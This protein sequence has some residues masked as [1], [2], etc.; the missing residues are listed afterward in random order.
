M[1]L[2]DLYGT[3]GTLRNLEE[4]FEDFLKRKNAI[5]LIRFGRYWFMNPNNADIRPIFR[6]NCQK[7][8]KLVRVHLRLTV[9]HIHF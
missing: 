7:L 4:H 8:G 3:L 9:T 6:I 1:T 2:G 5:N